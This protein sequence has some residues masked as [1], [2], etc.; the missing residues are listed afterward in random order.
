MALVLLVAVVGCEIHEHDDV[1]VEPIFHVSEL[2]VHNQTPLVLDVH[3][4]GRFVA[5]VSS[6]SAFTVDVIYGEH[7]VVAFDLDGY[8]VAERTLY[9]DGPLTWV[10]EE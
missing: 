2:T 9:L 4:D 3:L 6:Y 8:I 1:I 7:T 5:T 10:L